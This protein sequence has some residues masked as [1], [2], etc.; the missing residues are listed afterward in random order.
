MQSSTTSDVLANL[1]AGDLRLVSTSNIDET[2][3][4]ISNLSHDELKGERILA[5]VWDQIPPPTSILDEAIDQLAKA[6]LSLWPQWYLS[7]SDFDPVLPTLET[8]TE[9][10]R[11]A[12]LERYVLPH[13]V[14]LADKA[15]QTQRPP[16][17]ANEFTSEVEARQL[18]LALGGQACRLALAVDRSEQDDG[19]LLGL[20]RAAE[21]L[22]R[23]TK[24]PMFVLVPCEIAKSCELDSINFGTVEL[25]D[26]AGPPKFDRETQTEIL[27]QNTQLDRRTRKQPIVRRARLI[28]RPLIGRPHPDSAGEQLLWEKLRSDPELGGL[29]L[30]NQWTDTVCATTHLVDFVWRNGKLIVE[31]DGYYW[32][33]SQ[34]SFSRD[35][36]RDYEF[37]LSSYIV[38]RLPHDEVIA[39]VDG[40]IEKIRRLVHYR[41]QCL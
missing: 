17:W 40:A 8:L 33:S 36:R 21:W 4:R 37:H 23:E 39:D 6:A 31:V 24:L 13:W 28:V 2:I 30:C 9:R 14:Q 7:Q 5:L 26:E 3:A 35:R 19:A 29:F 27:A 41:Q 18:A 11:Q 38:L 15:C 25:T 10:I 12:R 34:Y 22:S 1:V 20:A 16:R 32:H